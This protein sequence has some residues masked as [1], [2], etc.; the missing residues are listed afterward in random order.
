MIY[1]G[2]LQLKR[3]FGAPLQISW[4]ATKPT[5]SGTLSVERP[6]AISGLGAGYLAVFAKEVKNKIN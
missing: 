1:Q 6:R 5:F 4:K 3:A 2:M